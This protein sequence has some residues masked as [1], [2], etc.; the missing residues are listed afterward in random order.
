MWLL[1]RPRTA[2]RVAYVVVPAPQAELVAGKH[3]LDD[4]TGLV[5]RPQ[6]PSDGLEINPEAGVLQFIPSG[7]DS[8]HQAP[9]AQM[10]DGGGHLCRDAWV[11]IGVAVDQRPDP[12][13]AGLLAERG[14]RGPSLQARTGRVGAHDRV[15]V[16][17]HP[18]R[19]VAP[20][21]GLLP[22]A[23]HLA[24]LGLL[25]RSLDSE[26][27]RMLAHCVFLR[28]G[29]FH[30]RGA[31]RNRQGRRVE[32]KS[33]ETRQTIKFLLSCALINVQRRT[34]SAQECRFAEL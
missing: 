9:G 19:V 20:Q 24:P 29:N 21:I 22:Q 14:Q 18:Q 4:L 2:D 13:A 34:C 11:A 1:Q 7:A 12:G 17:K 25:L 10:V 30:T 26:A 3:P 32:Q 6:T 5:Q 8:Q 23:A 15:E 16:I 31:A 27:H 33:R 28:A